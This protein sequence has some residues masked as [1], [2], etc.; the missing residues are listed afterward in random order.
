MAICYQNAIFCVQT[1]IIIG[2]PQSRKIDSSILQTDHDNVVSKFG[3]DEG[4]LVT[5]EQKRLDFFKTPP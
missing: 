3:V 4:Y 5:R 1:N 2:V